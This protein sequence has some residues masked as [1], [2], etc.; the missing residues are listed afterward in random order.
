MIIVN[1]EEY[2][3][4]LK[5]LQTQLVQ[6]QSWV[7]HSKAKIVILFEGRD[8]AGKG[9]VIKRITEK[10]SPRIFRTVALPAPTEREKS[11][12]YFQRYIEQMPA[13]GEVVIFDRSWYNR[14][15][16]EHVMGFC[17]HDQYE[18]FLIDA[19]KLEAFL[20]RGGTTLIKYFLDVSQEEQEKRFKKRLNDIKRQWKLSPM[21]LESYARWWDYTKA[22]DRMMQAT[23]TEFAPWHIVKA[24]DKYAARLN[25]ISHLLDIIPWEV[26]PFDK[27]ELPKIKSKGEGPDKPLYTNYIPERYI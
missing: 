1:K 21:D 18:E 14:A 27:P 17:T 15:G 26:I 7:V 12:I 5:Q 10:V 20:I 13:G 24:D 3:I 9:G 8:A 11:Q 4:E 6:L 2:E 16:V 19:P 25:C 22:I 23:D